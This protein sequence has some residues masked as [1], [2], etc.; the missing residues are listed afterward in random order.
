MSTISLLRRCAIL[1]PLLVLGCSDDG[2]P[3]NGVEGIG[4]YCASNYDCGAGLCCGTPACGHGMCTYR[5][6]GDIDCPYGALC[7][8]GYCFMSCRSNAD[9]YV[10]QKCKTARGVCQY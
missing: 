10:P 5:C 9:C 6:S 2:P 7:E 3:P 8:G 4:A 1:L